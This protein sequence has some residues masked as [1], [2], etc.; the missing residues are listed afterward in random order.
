MRGAR[1]GTGAR[2]CRRFNEVLGTELEVWRVI[3][4]RRSAASGASTGAARA[5]WGRP[6]RGLGSAGLVAFALAGPASARQPL[7]EPG[8]FEATLVR[9]ADGREVTVSA[10]THAVYRMLTQDGRIHGRAAR[11]P[12][13]V[14][15]RDGILLR[16]RHEPGWSARFGHRRPTPD[17]DYVFPVEGGALPSRS[18]FQPGHRAEDIFAAPGRRVLAPAAMLVVHAGY[19]SRT[20]GEAVVGFVPA[21]P[22]GSLRARYIVLVHLDATPAR[23]RVGEV[24]EAGSLLG[25]IA[26]GDEAVVGN[27]LG[28]P[29]HLHF[30][31]REERPDGHLEGIPPW[32]LLRRARRLPPG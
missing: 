19:L 6:W 25:H 2:R 3:A 21:A 23:A 12:T 10:E 9:L 15:V 18:A 31:I 27:A 8:P 13:E 32:D 29:P 17:P 20:A 11:A 7:I 1:A 22:P 30:V 16:R 4:P 26:A 28:R 5:R 14:E 24:L